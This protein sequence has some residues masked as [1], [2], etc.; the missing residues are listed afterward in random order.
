MTEQ[1]RQLQPLR[2]SQ[3]CSGLAVNSLAVDSAPINYSLNMLRLWARTGVPRCQNWMVS[4]AFSSPY[5]ELMSLPYREQIISLFS[6]RNFPPTHPPNV[7]LELLKGRERPGT[8]IPHWLRRRDPH[9]TLAIRAR[10]W[11]MLATGSASAGCA[12][13]KRQ[14]LTKKGNGGWGVNVIKYLTA[15]KCEQPLFAAPLLLILPNK[16]AE[17]SSN[18]A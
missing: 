18:K 14:N 12:G 10:T 8:L 5:I 3:C 9:P 6:R 2:R 16:A 11:V 13:G 15:G 17:S 4:D 7:H 1:T